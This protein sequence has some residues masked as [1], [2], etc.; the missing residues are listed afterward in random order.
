M[1]YELPRLQRFGS[2]RELT[3]VGASGTGDLIAGSAN[4][5]CGPTQSS[6]C[7]ARS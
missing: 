7:V 2:F 4:T 3:M 1:K 6:D 5:G